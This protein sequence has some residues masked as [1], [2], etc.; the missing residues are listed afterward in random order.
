MDDIQNMLSVFFE[1]P[2][3]ACR[4]PYRPEDLLLP[5][6]TSVFPRN[7][8]PGAPTVKSDDHEFKPFTSVMLPREVR[9]HG[10][11]IPPIIPSVEK[12]ILAQGVPFDDEM[13][14]RI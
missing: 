6:P 14:H 4:I 10:T 7:G 1:I 8:T 3:L 12:I 2:N 13:G 9:N 11:R 5:L